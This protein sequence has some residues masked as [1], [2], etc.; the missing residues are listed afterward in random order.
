M[1]PK[2]VSGFTGRK[3]QLPEELR[4]IRSL[5]QNEVNKV[6]S[7]Y[8]RMVLANLL[9]KIK[10]KKTPVLELAIAS[11]FQSSIEKG[12]FAKLNFLLDRCIGKIPDIIEDDDD[13]DSRED[14]GRLSMNELLTL[15]KSTIPQKVEE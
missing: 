4:G 15:V 5:T 7:K 6:I 3:K 12:D 13:S 11:I 2:G 1:Y 14:I 8:A 10:D 9:E